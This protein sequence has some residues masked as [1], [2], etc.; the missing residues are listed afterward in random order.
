MPYIHAFIFAKETY[1]RDDLRVDT[2]VR[3]IGEVG[4]W[5]RVPFSRI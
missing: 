3:L 4:G 2:G 5:G 1:K